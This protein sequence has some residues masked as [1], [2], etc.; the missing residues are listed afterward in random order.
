MDK[1]LLDIRLALIEQVIDHL[2]VFK[3][4][5][6]GDHVQGMDLVLLDILQEVIPVLLHRSL[7]IAN[8]TDPSLHQ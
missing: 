7:S 2:H 5:P 4:E 3:L 8:K 1:N 6:V